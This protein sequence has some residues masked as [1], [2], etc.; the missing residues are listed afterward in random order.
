MQVYFLACFE[1]SW[2]FQ[3]DMRKGYE[4]ARV[5]TKHVVQHL[6]IS[7]VPMSK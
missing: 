4:G 7:I 5:Y 1:S 3:L 2:K 6:A